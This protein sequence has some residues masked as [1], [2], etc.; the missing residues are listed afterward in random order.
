MDKQRVAVIKG[1][2]DEYLEIVHSDRNRKNGQMWRGIGQWN[3]DKPRGF[4]PSRIDGRLP[5]VVE[6]DISL[7]R[8]LSNNTNLVEYYSDPLTHME[9]QLRRS[10]N[11]HKMYQDNYVFTDELYIWFGVI[12]ELSLFGSEVIWQEHK[13]GWVKEPVLNNYDD[14]DKIAQPDFRTSGVMPK[15]HEFYEVMNEVAD[16]KMK[17]MFPELARGPFCMA[18]HMRGINDLFC[19]VLIEPEWVHKLMRFIVDSEKNWNHERTKFLGEKPLKA[20]LFNDEIDNPSI[21]PNIYDE[22][23]FPYEKEIGETYGGVRYFHSCGNITAF[24]PAIS[25]LPNLDV[26]HVGPWTSYEEADRI[27]GN[28]T[29]LE[30]CLHPV[31]DIVMADESAMRA[32]LEDIIDKCPHKNYSVRADALMP[33]GE[34]EPQLEKIRQWEEIA[35][36]YFG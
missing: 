31:N 35:R 12:T 27:M 6:L 14:L 5:Y 9:F 15:V 22:L 25:K 24:L 29:A 23:I 17:V 2:I 1:L 33:Q 20:K 28:Q 11:H 19:D 30:I 10:L 26:V 36:E 21:G 8:K 18:V 32:K 13:E 34:L 16:G 4:A 7:W 3:R